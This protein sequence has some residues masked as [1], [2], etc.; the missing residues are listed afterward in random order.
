MSVW[1]DLLSVNIT[2]EAYLLEELLEVLAGAS[3]PIN[4]EIEHHTEIVSDGQRVPA[5][6]VEFPVWRE[7][8]PQVKAI[9]ENTNLRAYFETVPMLEEI[10]A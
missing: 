6:R 9:V 4:P 5:V 2:V 8:L 10:R 3:F 7:H 1:Q